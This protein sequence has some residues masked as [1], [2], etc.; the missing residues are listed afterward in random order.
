MA[1][2]IG[3]VTSL[4]DLRRKAMENDSYVQLAKTAA[5]NL[6]AEGGLDFATAMRWLEMNAAETTERGVVDEV[7][8]VRDLV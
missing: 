6:G 8:F 3:K 1:R 4:A 2:L 7:N 5:R